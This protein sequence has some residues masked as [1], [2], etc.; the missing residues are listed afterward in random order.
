[1]ENYYIHYEDLKT[2]TS[3]TL[4]CTFAD[5]KHFMKETSDTIHNTT[6]NSKTASKQSQLTQTNLFHEHFSL[7]SLPIDSSPLKLSNEETSLQSL[8]TTASS[9]STSVLQS[10]STTHS[11][12][13][14]LASVFSSQNNTSSES[15]TSSSQDREIQD[16]LFWIKYMKQL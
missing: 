9:V 8:C 16:N 6:I 11:S 1:M 7:P 12:L 2:N 15:T 14:T 13:S 4:M 10:S 5:L 3:D